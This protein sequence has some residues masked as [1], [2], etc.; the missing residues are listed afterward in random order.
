MTNEDFSFNF[1]NFSDKSLIGQ[2]ACSL[3]QL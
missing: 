1:Y 3:S 2:A